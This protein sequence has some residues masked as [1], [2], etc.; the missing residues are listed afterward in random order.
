MSRKWLPGSISLLHGTLMLCATPLALHVFCIGGYFFFW[1]VSHFLSV[2]RS[3]ISRDWDSVCP[4]E[5]SI[6]G[7]TLVLEGMLY[8]AWQ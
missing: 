4:L 2:M 5:F 1:C 8:N 6:P 3:L 7:M